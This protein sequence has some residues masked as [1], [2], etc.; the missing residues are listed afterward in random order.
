MALVGLTLSIFR[1]HQILQVEHKSLKLSFPGVEVPFLNLVL[2]N[3]SFLLLRFWI[4]L[5]WVPL[6]E[7]FSGYQGCCYKEC[8]RSGTWRVCCRTT[9]TSLRNL[10]VCKDLA[11]WLL[12]RLYCIVMI[13]ECRNMIGPKGVWSNANGKKAPWSFLFIS[14]GPLYGNQSFWVGGCCGECGMKGGGLLIYQNF[15]IIIFKTGKIRVY[16]DLCLLNWGGEIVVF[17]SALW[18]KGEDNRIKIR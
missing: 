2:S 7:T 9:M 8:R 17:W 4:Y 18:R 10:S 16:F 11:L 5:F 13:E 15:F 1:L 14:S 12:W 6:M 3:V